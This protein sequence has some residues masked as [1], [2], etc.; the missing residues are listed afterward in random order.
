VPGRRRAAGG[1]SVSPCCSE[2]RKHGRPA[3]DAAT[4]VANNASL[5]LG[6]VRNV[7]SNRGAYIAS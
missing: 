7:C 3:I 6:E 2:S 4:R 5:E 1:G